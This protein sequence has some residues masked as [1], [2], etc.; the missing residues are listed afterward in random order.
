MAAE[1]LESSIWPDNSV[2]FCKKLLATD[3]Y[4]DKIGELLLAG[5]RIPGTVEEESGGDWTGS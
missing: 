1:S 3:K 4:S 2:V 5:Q